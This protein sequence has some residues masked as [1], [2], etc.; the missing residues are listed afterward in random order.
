M[1][2]RWKC[3]VRLWL[4]YSDKILHSFLNSARLETLSSWLWSIEEI[5]ETFIDEILIQKNPTY[6]VHSPLSGMLA[7][8]QIIKR[9][10]KKILIPTRRNISAKDRGWIL[11]N[12]Q[13]CHI[14]KVSS[15]LHDVMYSAF[16]YQIT[17]HFGWKA[18]K[19]NSWMLQSFFL[20]YFKYKTTLATTRFN[21]TN[22]LKTRIHTT[23]K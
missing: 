21:S 20:V 23:Y 16:L 22:V 9:P 13:I 5:S 19:I 4:T 18:L 1:Y 11:H 7:I 12:L 8:S 10:R 15:Y 17:L 14:Y 2:L 3:Y 6:E